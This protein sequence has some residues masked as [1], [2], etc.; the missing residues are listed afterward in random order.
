MRR[1]QVLEATFVLF[2]V[3]PL[4]VSFAQELSCEKL[5]PLKGSQSQYKKRLNRC[6][7][8]YEQDFGSKSLA[9][10]SFTLGPIIY[11]L[12]SGTKLELTVPKQATDVHIRA[13]ARP[14]NIAYEMDAVLNPGA[15]LTWPVD[16]VL[17]PEAL[18]AKQIGVFAW[19]EVGGVKYYTPALIVAAGL[20]QPKSDSTPL[21]SFRPSSDLQRIMW[22]WSQVAQSKCLASTEWAPTS[23][24]HINAGQTVS[25]PLGLP[26]GQY[27]LDVTTQDSSAKWSTS[28]LRLDIP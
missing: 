18:N 4:Q 12:Q 13:V 7:G 15:T 6:E 19:R 8:L 3:I 23:P 10:I 17:L 20:K 11:P 21:I 2:L 1:A 9:L 24:S 28:N 26:A 14:A 16:D 25:I 5:Q 22:R 27:C